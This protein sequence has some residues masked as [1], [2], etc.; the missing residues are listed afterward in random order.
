MEMSLE[1]GRIPRYPEDRMRQECQ[2]T[3]Y[4]NWKRRTEEDVAKMLPQRQRAPL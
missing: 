1:K 4:E 3:S 2:R